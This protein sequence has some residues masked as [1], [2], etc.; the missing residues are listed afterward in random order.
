MPF[1]KRVWALRL[2]ERMGLLPNDP[3]NTELV[4]MMVLGAMRFR[5]TATDRVEL[6]KLS[7]LALVLI[8]LTK[9]AEKRAAYQRLWDGGFDA[10]FLLA[11]A[12]RAGKELALENGLD[13]L[14]EILAQPLERGQFDYP[15]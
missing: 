4:M 7:D 5:K 1:E 14:A 10:E 3:A 11:S 9:M 12:K 8:A 13:T 6:G 15:E 2:T